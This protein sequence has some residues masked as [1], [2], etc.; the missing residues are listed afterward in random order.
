MMFFQEMVK[1]F[2]EIPGRKFD[3]FF[4]HLGDRLWHIHLRD[5]AGLDTADRKQELELTPGAGSVDFAKFAQALDRVDYYGD[6]TIE[7]EYRDLD[8]ES[9][10]RE[11]DKGLKYLKQ[12]GWKLPNTVKV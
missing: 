9:I 11:F 5:S 2:M 12:K 6:V 8:L 4:D 10:E 3:E 1:N 7:F